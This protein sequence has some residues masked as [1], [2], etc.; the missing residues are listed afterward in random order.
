MTRYALAP[1]LLTLLLA[2]QAHAEDIHRDARI[3][4]EMLTIRTYTTR[5][6]DE[7]A[8]TT[9]VLASALLREAGIDSRWLSCG[10][11]HAEGTCGLP[12]SST[13]LAMR[14]VRDSGTA[15]AH[16]PQTMGEA[17]VDPTRRTGVLATLYLDRIESL[18]AATGT[19]AG[20]ILARAIAH[21][22]AHLMLGTTEHG[23]IGLM[24]PLWSRDMLRQEPASTWVFTPDEGE[25]LRQALAA[26]LGDR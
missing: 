19:D 2:H 14:L 20:V 23:S 25:R 24:R 8:T 10:V 12:L 5:Q 16:G 18:S 1:M 17:L 13:E 26:R 21:E 11:A 4:A 7:P 9:L 22:A 6:R 15:P 3:S